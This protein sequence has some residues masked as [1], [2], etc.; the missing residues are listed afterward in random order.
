MYSPIPKQSHLTGDWL[1]IILI[2]LFQEYERTS[3]T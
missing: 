1:T 3:I 2:R